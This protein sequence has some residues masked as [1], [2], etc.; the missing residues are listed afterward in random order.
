MICHLVI[1]S[2]SGW[3]MVDTECLKEKNGSP[4]DRRKETLHEDLILRE[5]QLRDYVLVGGVTC[6]V[7][8]HVKGKWRSDC[9]EKVDASDVATSRRC[10]ASGTGR[11]QPTQE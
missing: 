5:R 3:S 10:G 4:R 11:S 7:L 6:P 2:G 9:D 8:V 1:S